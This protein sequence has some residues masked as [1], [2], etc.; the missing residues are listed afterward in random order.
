MKR[1]LL[2]ISILI[3]SKAASSQPLRKDTID[4]GSFEITLAFPS[5]LKLYSHITNYEEGFYKDYS[6]SNGLLIFVHYGGMAEN[7]VEADSI[8]YE[9]EM[10]NVAS[11][12][13]YMKDKK[14]FRIDNYYQAGVTISFQFVNKDNL[15]I[16]EDILNT[17]EINK[18]F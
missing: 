16:A 13:L 8:I 3:F 18:L 15:T 2:L 12:I 14:Y 7:V 10:G 17:I 9:C 11:S 1:L 4:C 6:L 5:N